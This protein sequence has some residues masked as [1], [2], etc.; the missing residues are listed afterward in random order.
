MNRVNGDAVLGA[1]IVVASVLAVLVW[2]PR[3]TGSAI[4]EV[5]RGSMRIGDALAPTIGFSLLGIAGLILMIEARATGSTLRLDRFDLVFIAGV[6]GI[7]LCAMLLMRWSGPLAAALFS[8]E[9]YRNLRGTLPWKYVGFIIGGGFM[10]G[11]LISLVDRRLTAR[12][13]LLGFVVALCL[14]LVY[15]LPFGSLLLP[16]NGDV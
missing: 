1:A 12:V 2:V 5:V 15:D 14:A 7:F 16:P 8:D 9:S 11:T 4:V 13:Y 3:D 10:I 6:G